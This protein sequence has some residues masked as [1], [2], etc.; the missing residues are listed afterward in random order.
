MGPCES[1]SFGQTFFAFH[2]RTFS[3][4]DPGFPVWGMD[5]FWE[6]GVHLQRGHF[7]VKMYVKTKELGTVGKRAP[8]NFA[9]RSANASVFVRQVEEIKCKETLVVVPIHDHHATQSIGADTHAGRYFS[10]SS[11]R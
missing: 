7:L 9:C 3:G 11:K 5:P 4:A 10:N 2:S 1:P 6:R 8:E